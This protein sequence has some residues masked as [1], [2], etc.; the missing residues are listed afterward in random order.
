M[1]AAPWTERSTSHHGEEQQEMD[2]NLGAAMSADWRQREARRAMGSQIPGDQGLRP[3]PG[4]EEEGEVGRCRCLGTRRVEER[5][6]AGLVRRDPSRGAQA[7]A[8]PRA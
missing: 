1:E 4:R 7:A 6:E 8:R 5:E 3:R 2:E